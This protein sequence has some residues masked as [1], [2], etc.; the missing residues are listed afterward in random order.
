MDKYNVKTSEGESFDLAIKKIKIL[1]GSHDAHHANE[2]TIRDRNVALKS[3]ECLHTVGYYDTM[4]YNGEIWICMELMDISL[5]RFFPIAHTLFA[6]G[7]RPPNQPAPV[8]E[9]FIKKLSYQ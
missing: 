5:D 6:E 1:A 3:R 7:N 9:A 2:L 8:P 4:C